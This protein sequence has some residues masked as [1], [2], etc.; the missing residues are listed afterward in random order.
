[1]WW[2]VQSAVCLLLAQAW[3]SKVTSYT[4]EDD[5]CVGNDQCDLVFLGSFD[6]CLA[7]VPP[8]CVLRATRRV[9][10]DRNDLLIGPGSMP[11]DNSYVGFNGVNAGVYLTH[12]PFTKDWPRR[13]EYLTELVI[14]W[15][16]NDCFENDGTMLYWAYDGTRSNHPDV[17]PPFMPDRPLWEFPNYS[18]NRTHLRIPLDLALEH[19]YAQN[20]GSLALAFLLDFYSF[21]AEV[22]W[23]KP[24]PTMPNSLAVTSPSP[25]SSRQLSRILYWEACDFAWT[26]K[27]PYGEVVFYDYMPGTFG[28]STPAPAVSSSAIQ[29]VP[30]TDVPRADPG[31]EAVAPKALEPSIFLIPLLALALAFSYS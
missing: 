23:P 26:E 27:G 9:M 16:L 4:C 3:T 11:D 20:N 17:N 2:L 21:G 7:A 28:V 1:M 13:I 30:V 14:D 5:C 22:T 6:S 24:D 8:T 31:F 15:Q 19:Q 12:G 10:L 18:Y 25:R 29:H